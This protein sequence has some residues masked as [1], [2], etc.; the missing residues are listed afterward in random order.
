MSVDPVLCNKVHTPFGEGLCDKAGMSW[1]SLWLQHAGPAPARSQLRPWVTLQGLRFPKTG[2]F[3]TSQTDTTPK[4]KRSRRDV[5]H[6]SLPERLF[7]QTMKTAPAATPL[8]R[9]ALVTSGY[10]SS[11]HFC[12]GQCQESLCCWSVCLQRRGTKSL[13]H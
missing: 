13:A 12:A 11:R 3:Q 1:S 5:G 9:A 4:F 6:G 8:P 10:D 7:V 2:F